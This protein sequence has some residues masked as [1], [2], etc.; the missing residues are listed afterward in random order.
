MPI[1][2]RRHG[3]RGPLNFTSNSAGSKWCLHPQSLWYMHVLLLSMSLFTFFLMQFFSSF[4]KTNEWFCKLVSY[5][6]PNSLLRAGVRAIGPTN[7]WDLMS[8]S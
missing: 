3:P 6:L 7:L 5:N 8:L 1:S 4:L 2:E